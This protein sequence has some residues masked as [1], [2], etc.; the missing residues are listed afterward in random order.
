MERMEVEMEV[1]MEM[2]EIEEQKNEG[3]GRER[4]ENHKRRQRR[5]RETCLKNQNLSLTSKI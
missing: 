1:G 2:G 5:G 4:G 3:A